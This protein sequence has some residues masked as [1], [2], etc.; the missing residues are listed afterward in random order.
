MEIYEWDAINPSSF[1]KYILKEG[2]RKKGQTPTGLYNTIMKKA[3]QD[4]GSALPAAETAAEIFE[5][6]KFKPETLLF[7]ELV[8][9]C[10]FISRDL[11]S[12]VKT[13]WRITKLNY[14]PAENVA[15]EL[16]QIMA[17][18]PED[19]GISIDHHPKVFREAGTIMYH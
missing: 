18:H 7:L 10:H 5:K 6:K 14:P 17:D 3:E 9:R 1:K 11:N 16:T 4:L 19:F 8:T 15:L 12:V 2:Y 13:I